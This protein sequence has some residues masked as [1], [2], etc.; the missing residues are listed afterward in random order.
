M[1]EYH[2][3]AEPCDGGM[4]IDKFLSEE[5]EEYSRSFLQKLIREG[6]VAVDERTVKANYK[7]SCGQQI[8]VMV[9]EPEEVSI[10]PENIPLDILYEDEDVLVINKPKDMVVHP[11]AGHYSHTL[12]NGIMY[13]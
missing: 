6:L 9:R 10:E 13:H 8:L 3:T 12:V 11:A 5:M 7:L 2:F 1:T 4:R